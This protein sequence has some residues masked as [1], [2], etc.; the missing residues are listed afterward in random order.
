MR[1]EREPVGGPQWLG[2]VITE[3]YTHK[4]AQGNRDDAMLHG[5][6]QWSGHATRSWRDGSRQRDGKI[7]ERLRELLAQQIANRVTLFCIFFA[8]EKEQA[9]PPIMVD[10]HLCIE[11]E[12]LAPWTKQC[13]RV[14]QIGKSWSKERTNNL[15][16]K[17]A[18]Q[19]KTGNKNGHSHSFSQEK[20]NIKDEGKE[21]PRKM[22]VRYRLSDC[23]QMC[24]VATTVPVTA[25]MG[26]GLCTC[27][28]RYGLCGSSSWLSTVSA[29]VP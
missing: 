29:I 1:R 21:R 20:W 24:Q 25:V 19:I 14:V 13:G 5:A 17:T 8:Q 23:E 7:G 9:R 12:N 3:L 2:Q 16:E 10:G 4:I 11:P 22:S 28:E 15:P 6:S 27:S 26:Q 18:A